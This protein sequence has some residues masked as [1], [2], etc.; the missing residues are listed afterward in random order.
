M[1]RERNQVVVVGGGAAGMI[2][3]AAAAD[4]G[5]RV[6]I[7][8]KNEKLGKKLYIT[9]KGRCNV[10]NACERDK[11]FENI[12]SNPKFLYS[13]FHELDNFGVM[14]LLENNGCNLKTER[15]E[16]V[17]PVSD[18][19]SDVTAAFQ[20]L[21]RKKG[22]E[23]RLHCAVRGIESKEG[24]AAG[25]I[26]ADGSAIP[27]EA[28]IVATGGLSYRTTGSTGDGH[29]MA[30]ELGHR[31]KACEPALVPLVIREECCK[32]LQGLSLK[33]VS[34]TMS[35]GKKKL[36]QGF[37]EM[38]F[39]HYGVSGPLVLSASSFLGKRKG[40]EELLLTVDLKPAL[41]EEQLDKRILRDFEEN[42]NR[43]FKNA[44]N[45]LYPSKLISV[46]IERSGID[47]EK[48]VHEITRQER[49][50]LSELTKAFTLHVREKRGFDEAVITQGGVSVKEINP[51]TM[52][53]RLVRG[54]Y[55]AGEVLD[56]DG[57]TGGFNLQ[58]AW[59]TGYLAG[60]SC[61]RK[62]KE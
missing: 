48:K 59:S 43:Q 46:M 62:G 41:S 20:R 52:E 44:L 37:G 56:L 25:V 35:C 9:G 32:K 24:Q 13:A 10:T 42:L 55:F 58:I 40:E 33:N 5:R 11:F 22:V 31:V 2:A 60:I 30:E 15:G 51:S 57:L 6:I 21:L 34:L 53:S 17:F 54:L 61:A 38:L 36:Y 45:G 18:H 28:V 19:A 47:P 3:A 50:R 26:L 14:A 4:S 49:R 8:E 23:V 39:T 29:R 16:R 7:L 12:V 1:D 27:A